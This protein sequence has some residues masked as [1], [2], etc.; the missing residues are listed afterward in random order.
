[1]DATRG[2]GPASAGRRFPDGFKIYDSDRVMFL[3][4]CLAQLQ[5]ATAEGVPVHGYFHWSAQDNLEWLSGFGD[6]FGLIHVNFGTLQRTPKLSAQWFREA[7]RHN[8]V[9]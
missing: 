7:A 6:R 8:A 9:V 1:M 2:A 5:R 3:R 4:A